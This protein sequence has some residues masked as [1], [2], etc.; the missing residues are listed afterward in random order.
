MS[1][2]VA[3]VGAV[4]KPTSVTVVLSLLIEYFRLSDVTK[5][6]AVAVPPLKRRIVKGVTR[7]SYHKNR[8]VSYSVNYLC[9][10][11]VGIKSC[12]VVAKIVKKLLFALLFSF[13]FVSSQPGSYRLAYVCGCKV[14]IK[15]RSC[16]KALFARMVTAL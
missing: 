12:N 5:S 3:V 1:M 13:F 7:L 15:T 6:A 4:L 16:K 14:T 11:S 8:V 10:C 2:V 9:C